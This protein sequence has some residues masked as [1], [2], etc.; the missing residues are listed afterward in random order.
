MTF[1]KRHQRARRQHQFRDGGLITSVPCSS[2]MADVMLTCAE[3]YSGPL[4]TYPNKHAMQKVTICGLEQVCA[5]YMQPSDTDSNLGSHFTGHQMQQK[6]K[7]QDIHWHFHPPYIPTAV[8][9]TEC[10]NG[11]LKQ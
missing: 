7:G 2:L 11:L 5:V 10:R 8:E 6:A 9:L 3:T 1:A 4:Q